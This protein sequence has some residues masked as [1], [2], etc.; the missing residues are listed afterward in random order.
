M[1]K[2][3]INQ[4]TTSKSVLQGRRYNVPTLR[5]GRDS[6]HAVNAE[7][8]Q[9]NNPDDHRNI[10]EQSEDHQRRRSRWSKQ[11]NVEPMKKNSSEARQTESTH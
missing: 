6:H 8:M 10:S 7:N 11:T 9:K 3:I 4:L 5:S 1:K 2:V